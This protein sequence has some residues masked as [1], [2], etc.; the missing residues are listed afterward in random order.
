[1]A[2]TNTRIPIPP[3]QWVK[4]L[5]KSIQRGRAST[6]ERILAP[7]VV[8]PEAVSNTASIMEGMHPEIRKG[9]APKILSTNQARATVINP[10]L[11]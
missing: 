8:K 4:L 11:A 5:Q 3:I 10:S 1:M 2:I 9:S 6:S 7:V